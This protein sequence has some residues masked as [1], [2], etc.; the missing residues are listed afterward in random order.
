MGKT[1]S[2]WVHRASKLLK[3]SLGRQFLRIMITIAIHHLG[4][5]FFRT[6]IEGQ[7]RDGRRR[8]VRE[9]YTK[10]LDHFGV[11]DVDTT[12]ANVSSKRC[13]ISN[14]RRVVAI[15]LFGDIHLQVNVT[16]NVA[17]SQVNVL[18]YK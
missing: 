6:F 3:S 12:I 7:K 14:S 5:F 13:P 1:K 17:V 4:S 16:V 8:Q 2:H 15:N 9:N 10:H 18:N 11:S